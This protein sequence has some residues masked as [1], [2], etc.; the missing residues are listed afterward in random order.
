MVT[1]RRIAEFLKRFPQLVVLAYYLYRLVQPKYSVG[2]VGVI[3]NEKHEILIVEHIYHPKN[4]WGL[5]GGWT[6]A[7]EDPQN[8]IIREAKEELDLTIKI[9]R[10]LLLRHT[11]RKHLD[12]AYLCQPVNEIGQLNSEILDYAWRAKSELPVLHPFH[13]RAIE[14]AFCVLERELI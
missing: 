6:N 9:E 3:L 8:T 13:W 1:K 14:T 7:N 11:G 5:P 4:P 10:L 12:I 2:V